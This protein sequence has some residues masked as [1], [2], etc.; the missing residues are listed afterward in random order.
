[1]ILLKTNSMLAVTDVAT[2]I[3]WTRPT[4][5]LFIILFF[6][7]AAF[8]YGMSLGRDRTIV[9]L[10]AIYMSLAV[11]RSLPDTI[12]IPGQPAFNISAFL[13]LFV[14]LFFL[15]SRMALLRTIASGDDKGSWWQVIVF[16]TLHVGLL[17]SVTLSFLPEPAL[18]H[19]TPM[20]RSIFV[21]ELAALG[22]LIAPILI[23]VLVSG[24]AAAKKKKYKYD[25]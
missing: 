9:I 21:D 11:V 5:D 10:V 20:T 13:G 7:V 2:Q 3:D 24:G 17:I 6:V 18:E 16:S 15:L 23:M 25:I 1:M 22:W 8:L 14:L 19:L 12:N 4:W